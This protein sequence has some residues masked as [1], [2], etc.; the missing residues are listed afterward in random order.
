MYI[1][2]HSYTYISDLKSTTHE[3]LKS[4]RTKMGVKA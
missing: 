1:Y 2:I 3:V 4:Q